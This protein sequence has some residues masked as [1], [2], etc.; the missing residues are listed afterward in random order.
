[1]SNAIQR[2]APE[3]EAIELA[4]VEGDLSRLSSAQRRSYYL[5]V[6]QS[7]DL[8]PLTRPF[9]YL[10]LNGKLLL[11]AKKDCTD[12]LRGRRG[13]SLD[14]VKRVVENGICEVTARATLDGRT[15]T[16]VGA[17]FV[18]GLRGE[19]LANAVMKA[20]TKAKRRVTLS[21]CGLSIPD[22]SEVETIRG[23]QAIEERD[24]P[25]LPARP[26]STPPP[27][28][29]DGGESSALWSRFSAEITQAPDLAALKAIGVVIKQA[30]PKLTMTQLAELRD[31]TKARQKAIKA[32]VSAEEA[33]QG[34]ELPA[35]W[36][37]PPEP[38]VDPV[39]ET[40]TVCNRPLG[41]YPTV[42]V[43]NADGEVGW[44]HAGC[45]AA[46]E[47]GED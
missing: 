23:A 19:A 37:G 46:R 29:H 27:P 31:L 16:D 40:C 30:G 38:D 18:D 24:V 20:H 11:Y 21:I 7:L 2:H 34:N 44:R 47:P 9:E 39:E 12:Q 8:N 25:Q 22:E 32:G 15:D 5:S 17:V 28:L 26:A 3:D 36:G 35:A 6:C 1:M 43:D 14:I 41:K 4:L 33:L 42:Q 10:R 13:V 45:A